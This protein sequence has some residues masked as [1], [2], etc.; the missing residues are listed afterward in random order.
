MVTRIRAVLGAPYK[1][2]KDNVSGPMP[3]WIVTLSHPDFNRR[4]RNYTG[5]AD[6]WE[7]TQSARGLSAWRWFTAGG[8]FRPAL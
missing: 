4:P 7:F 6:L 1:R 5:S 3:D 8:E 2:Q